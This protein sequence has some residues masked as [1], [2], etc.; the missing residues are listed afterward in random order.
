[1]ESTHLPELLS[2]FE[3]NYLYTQP[4]SNHPISPLL[5]YSEPPLR[6]TSP[7]PHRIDNILT[8]AL[9]EVKIIMAL[10]NLNHK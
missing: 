1:M 7:H 2:T 8:N 5:R 3:T 9:S 6:E 4:G 10:A